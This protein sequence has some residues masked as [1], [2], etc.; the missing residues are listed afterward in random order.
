[1]APA[2]DKEGD[3]PNAKLVDVTVT[4]C[5]NLLQTRRGLVAASGMEIIPPLPTSCRANRMQGQT[6]V[7]VGASQ[8]SESPPGADLQSME[9]S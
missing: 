4:A 8:V 5:S 7:S 2:K 9:D 1:M 3:G 6:V